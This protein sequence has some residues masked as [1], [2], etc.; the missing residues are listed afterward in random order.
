MIRFE[1]PKDRLMKDPNSRKNPKVR[2]NSVASAICTIKKLNARRA[3]TAPM[4]NNVML[5][6]FVFI[7]MTHESMQLMVCTVEYFC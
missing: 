1:I 5:L 2:S 7:H 3:S 4:K 6:L